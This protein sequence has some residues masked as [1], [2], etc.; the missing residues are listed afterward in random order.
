MPANG[1]D[2]TI[3]G[4]FKLAVKRIAVMLNCL[5]GTFRRGDKFVME[6]IAMLLDRGRCART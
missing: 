6:S 4:G 3:R 2:G 1:V 5:N